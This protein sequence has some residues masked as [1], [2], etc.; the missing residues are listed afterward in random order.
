MKKINDM[1]EIISGSPQ[2]RI[3]EVI[4]NIAPRYTYYSQSEIDSDL[5]DLDLKKG[6][7]KKVRTFD[8]VITVKNQDIVFSLVSGKASLVR[9]LHQG[10]LLTQNY[11][12]LNLNEQVN[13]KY[14]IYLLN[15]DASIRR[16][17]QIGLQGST[18]LKYTLKQVKEIE[19][20][21]MPLLAKQELIGEIYFNQL[22]LQALQEQASQLETQIVLEKIKRNK[23]Q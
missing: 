7:E 21:D 20:P 4:D 15:E 18:V 10:Y 19:L 17:L 6:E 23:Y 3:N 14:L 2:F 1:I 12:K 22:R 16:Q 8:D 11:L 13:A 5:V 9:K